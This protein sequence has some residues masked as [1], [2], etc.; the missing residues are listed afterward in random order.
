[1]YG[2]HLEGRELGKTVINDIEGKVI[3]Q[4]KLEV[5]DMAVISSSVHGLLTFCSAQ[6]KRFA[7]TYLCHWLCGKLSS[8][9]GKS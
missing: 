6:D 9:F 7:N 5:I 1:M 4:T 8:P 3:R 2:R